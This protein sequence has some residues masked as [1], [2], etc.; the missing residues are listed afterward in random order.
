MTRATLAVRARRPAGFLLAAA[1]AL[2]AS[3]AAAD[4]NDARALLKAMSD[5][6]GAQ[7]TLSFGFDSALAIVTT[8]LQ[9]LELA[10]SGTVALSRPDKLR[11]TRTGGYADVEVVFDGNQLSILGKDIGKYVQVPVPGTVEAL[12]DRLRERGIEAPGADLL[13]A[14]LNTALMEPVI[15][16][17]DLGSGVIHGVECNHLAFR[18]ESVDWQI[19]I[20]MGEDPHP[21][22]YVVTSKLMALAPEYR[23]DVYDWKA[24]SAAVADFSFDPGTATKG[25]LADLRN[26]DELPDLSGEGAA[27]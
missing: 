22:R 16:V 21:C 20:S 7:E 18:T 27:Q 12:I 3:A 13:L 24:G 5:Y 11:M 19:W 17:K 15:D 23:V 8:D 10:S 1:L 6:M 14:D 4:E 26:I 9:K 25:E 2:G